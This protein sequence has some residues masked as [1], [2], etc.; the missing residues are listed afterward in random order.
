MITKNYWRY[1]VLSIVLVLIAGLAPGVQPVRA[2]GE[3]IIFLHHSVGEGLVD[4][5]HMREQLTALGYEFYDHGYNEEGLRLADGTWTGTNFGV[6]DDNT[7]P[8]GY[9]N[10]FS[11]P[12]HDPP[13]NT[14]SY[15]MQYDVIIFKSCFSASNIWDDSMLADYLSD[16]RQI[17]DVMDAHPE[18]LF[19]VVTPPPN[20][21]GSTSPDEA[22]RARQ[23]ADWLASSEFLDGHPNVTTF[24]LFG[25]L[26]DSDNYLR[27]EYRPGGDSHPNT[28]ANQ[29]VGAQF[30][31]FIDQAIR[32]W[33]AGELGEGGAPP[34]PAISL[35]APSE[36]ETGGGEESYEEEAEPS[37]EET[38]PEDYVIFQSGALPSPDFDAVDDTMLVDGPDSLQA[39]G[40]DYLI[41][42]QDGDTGTTHLLIRFD[43]TPEMFPVGAAI[44]E[45]SL[46]LYHWGPGDD[47]GEHQAEV[48]MVTAPWE[49]G[50]GVWD[51]ES[52]IPVDGAT[53]LLA[54][55]GVPWA[56]EGGDFDPTPVAT[57]MLSGY[58]DDW[59]PFDLTEPV[60]RWLGGEP[61][62]GVLIRLTEPGEFDF[63][64]SEYEDTSLHPRLIVH[65][66][67]LVGPAEG[68]QGE[69]GGAPSEPGA[70]SGG[71][72]AGG[73]GLCSGA[74]A[75][76]MLGAVGIVLRW[77]A[78]ATRPL[79]K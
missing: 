3:R 29:E 47:E 18:R 34:P 8:D 46:E 2:V 22:A 48:F 64:G 26:A 62:Y 67:P 1:G 72:A 55:P 65:L 13:D 71:E 52:G 61:N 73:G 39:G 30:A 53:W 15:L 33:N 77:R 63:K 79:E 25:A 9:A 74:G 10:I 17:R 41:L 56:S 51:S 19:I 23:F 69:S 27:A 59:E 43:L 12:I 44:A 28:R 5:G 68:G 58:T 76:L 31:A 45:A 7:E 40:Y 50:T 6:P 42:S 16:Y 35:P 24:D 66:E 36:E 57:T 4:E 60:I 20:D 32:A 75:V 14:F 11:Q 49:E 70:E 54:M 37:G 38:L 78:G 21:P